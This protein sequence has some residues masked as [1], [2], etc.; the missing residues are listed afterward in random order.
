[1]V[2]RIAA[3]V[4]RKGP[5]PATFGFLRCTEDAAVLAGLLDAARGFAAGQEREAMDGPLSFTI[6]HEVGAQAA[7]FG[8]AP[9]LRMPR[10][11]PGCPG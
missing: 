7:A 2:G 6:N 9:M 1:V 11:P 3:C 4:P 8:R 10:T 5:G